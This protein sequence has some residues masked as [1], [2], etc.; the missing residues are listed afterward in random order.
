MGWTLLSQGFPRGMSP[1]EYIARDV[2]TWETTNPQ[3]VYRRQ[4]V[5][6]WGQPTRGEVYYAVRQERRERDA[7]T[8]YVTCVVVLIEGSKWKEID[9]EMHPYYYDCPAEVF[10]ALTP[11][12]D[13]PHG[14]MDSSAADWRD[15]VAGRLADKPA[16]MPKRRKSRVSA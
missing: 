4:S 6:R 14:W 16:P 13:I 9:E 1:A 11:L 8:I 5:V 3:G 15:I 10:A 7:T 2:L 12:A